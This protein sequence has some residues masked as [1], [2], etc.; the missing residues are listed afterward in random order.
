MGRGCGETASGG[1]GNSHCKGL[2]MEKK[3]TGGECPKGVGGSALSCL[4]AQGDLKTGPEGCGQEEAALVFPGTPGW[5]LADSG[6]FLA[7]EPLL[8]APPAASLSHHLIPEGWEQEIRH[9]RTCGDVSFALCEGRDGE[10]YTEVMRSSNGVV[11]LIN[12]NFIP[13]D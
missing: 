12:S 7:M 9:L 4:Y 11:L 3:L 5:V 13:V 6:L 2:E 1:K 10:D 8:S